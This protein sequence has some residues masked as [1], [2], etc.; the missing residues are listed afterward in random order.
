MHSFEGLI[1]E[2][3]RLGD[4][5]YNVSGSRIMHSGSAANHLFES[6]H[7]FQIV[8][9]QSGGFDLSNNKSGAL[10]CSPPQTYLRLV[11]G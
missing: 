11:K 3:Q 2:W 10:P 7:V 8:E 6:T 9:D 5:H 1:T 4:E